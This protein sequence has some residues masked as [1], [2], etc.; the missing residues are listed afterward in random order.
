[1]Q[2]AALILALATAAGTAPDGAPGVTTPLRGLAAFVAAYPD[3]LAGVEDGHLVWR[4]GER[5]PLEALG[6]DDPERTHTVALP[7]PEDPRHAA[8]ESISAVRHEPIYRRIYGDCR[9][10]EVEPQLVAV[11]WNRGAP[12]GGRTVTAT[13]V[14][15][16]ADKLQR[17]SDELD[18]LGPE[19]QR[20]L[21]PLGGTYMCRN[22]ALTN[23]ASLHSYGVAVDINPAHGDYWLNQRGRRADAPRPNR[24]PHEI[25]EVFERHGFV[26]GGRWHRYDTFHFEYRPE[27]MLALAGARLP[28]P[29]TS[30]AFV[31]G[32][33]AERTAFAGMA[34]A[35]RA[36]RR[37]P[38]FLWVR[39]PGPRYGQC[40]A[41]RPPTA[42]RSAG[43]SRTT[44]N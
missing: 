23:R 21:R 25:V 17:V 28:D 44:G 40:L 27:Y 29:L 30:A 20:Y 32:R 4:D 24:I 41:P 33:R 31:A 39:Q 8:T 11:R 6:L 14:N 38:C 34:R 26:W 19:F 5:M 1:M 16:V 15:G 3:H 12:D 42:A 22:I 7:P 9:A 13:R 36:E 2:F 35:A 18:A 43:V 37:G 10:G